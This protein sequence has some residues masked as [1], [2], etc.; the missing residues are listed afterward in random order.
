MD[1]DGFFNSFYVHIGD[2]LIY[3]V[4]LIVP[5]KSISSMLV[6]HVCALITF[7]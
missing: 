6:L 7:N 1:L 5:D 2:M 4:L 3:K